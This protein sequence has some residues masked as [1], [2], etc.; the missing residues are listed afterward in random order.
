MGYCEKTAGNK[1]RTDFFPGLSDCRVV[2]LSSVFHNGGASPCE[3]PENPGTTFFFR[4]MSLPFFKSTG[5]RDQKLADQCTLHCFRMRT[6]GDVFLLQLA[7]DFFYFF[8]ILRIKYLVLRKLKI[9]C[10]ILLCNKMKITVPELL[11][12]LIVLHLSWCVQD[13]GISPVISIPF[14]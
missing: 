6:A 1:R 7:D 12:C 3:V 9:F 5:C 2:R 13:A 10:R 4:V 14:S 8:R 11:Y